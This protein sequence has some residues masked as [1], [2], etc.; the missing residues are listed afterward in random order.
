M[1]NNT[2][3][4][5]GINVKVTVDL[6]PFEKLE[7]T[8][9]KLDK[10]ISGLGKD[11]SKQITQNTKYSQSAKQAEKSF[12]NWS[13]NIKRNRRTHDEHEMSIRGTS[14]ALDKN[15]KMT[16]LL[17][18]SVSGSIRPITKMRNNYHSLIGTIERFIPLG[19]GLHFGISNIVKESHSANMETVDWLKNLAQL[20]NTTGDASGALGQMFEIFSMSKGSLATIQQNMLSLGAQGIKPT[21]SGFKELV[22]MVTNISIATGIGAES[23]SS[24]SG[25]L[26][27]NWQYG[28]KATFEMTSSLIA[29]QKAFDSTANEI[30]LT[31]KTTGDSIEK[32][33]SFFDDGVKSAKSL[34]KGV[35]MTVGVLTKL[36]V[37]AQKANEFVGNLLDPEKMSENIVLFS[38]MG[39]SYGEMMDMMSSSNSKDLVFDKLLQNLPVVAQ[40]IQSIANPMAKMNFAKSIGLPMEIAQKMSKATTQDIQKL[41]LDYKQASEKDKALKEKQEKMAFESQRFED[42]LHMF[43]RDALGPMMAW[44]NAHYKDFM[45]IAQIAFSIFK[46]YVGGLVNFFNLVE[47]KMKPAFDAFKGGAG[48]DVFMSKLVDGLLGVAGQIFVKVGSFLINNIPVVATN[49]LKTW[50][51]LL[52]EHPLLTGIATLIGGM[53]VYSKV[54]GTISDFKN[55]FMKQGSNRAR[56]L[57]VKD[58]DKKDV[59]NGLGG[60]DGGLGGLNGLL[61]KIPGV[62]KLGNAMGSLSKLAGP[63][64]KASLYL[65]PIIGGITGAMNA[66]DYF[67]K[68]NAGAEVN[69]KQK[70]ASIAAGAGTLGIAP[71]IDSMFGTDLTGGLARSMVSGLNW[72]EEKEKN[73]LSGKTDLVSQARMGELVEKETTTGMGRFFESIGSFYGNVVKRSGQ[74]MLAGSVGGLGGAALGAQMGAVYGVYEQ[75]PLNELHEKMLIQKEMS[76]QET[77][78]LAILEEKYASGKTLSEEEQ[79][80]MKSLQELKMYGMN[81]E[82]LQLKAKVEKRIEQLRSSGKKEDA[83]LADQLQEQLNKKYKYLKKD[84]EVSDRMAGYLGKMFSKMGIF[85][86]DMEGIAKTQKALSNLKNDFYDVF[87][88]IGLYFKKWVADFKSTFSFNFEIGG[89]TIGVGFSKEVAEKAKQESQGY[90]NLLDNSVM[91]DI[92]TNVQSIPQLEQMLKDRK[93]QILQTGGENEASRSRITMLEGYANTQRTYLQMME[94]DKKAQAEKIRQAQ[95]QEEALKNS[96][97][98]T[99]AMGGIAKD[100]N[101]IKDNTDKQKSGTANADWISAFIGSREAFRIG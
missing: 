96:Q 91:T 99:N 84:I 9:S 44:V 13:N 17:N 1:G 89:H 21:I 76:K 4:G 101:A 26:V 59:S 36:G 92:F 64:S 23:F 34:T 83:M 2:G 29:M 7:K 6:K 75:I 5:K 45:S 8:L 53:K 31:M 32:M 11:I 87:Q 38:R 95:L 68:E 15:V 86:T 16:D 97:K 81:Q 67:K 79:K 50:W 55:A 66:E 88:Q 63:L 27:R 80:R 69:A 46:K 77:D 41:M 48:F 90:A 51:L 10:Q 60:K 65:A 61:K 82:E 30:E 57:F 35:A 22:A 42:T 20:S 72:K 93:N 62:G 49:I 19:I 43:K 18:A 3:K 78:E 56:P 100:V 40:Q 73:K 39:I 24:F 94:Q 25:I 28:V 14:D 12:D 71:L 98:Q 33:A 70:R 85:D 52:K 37:S 54:V 47:E 58:V 74:G